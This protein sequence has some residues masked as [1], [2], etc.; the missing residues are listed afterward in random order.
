MQPRW[1][2]LG[3]TRLYPNSRA[4]SWHCIRRQRAKQT[5]AAATAPAA[6]AA[7]PGSATASNVGCISERTTDKRGSEHDDGTPG[8]SA[9]SVDGGGEKPRVLA[10]DHA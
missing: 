3:S 9:A 7:A 8:R 4:P 1:E 2:K 5:T 6:T 10:R